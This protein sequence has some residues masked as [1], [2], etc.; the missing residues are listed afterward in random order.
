MIHGMRGKTLKGQSE[1]ISDLIGTDIEAAKRMVQ[2]L[3]EIPM[4]ISE[5]A[6][7]KSLEMEA[8]RTGDIELADMLI[9]RKPSKTIS[10]AGQELGMARIGDS[11]TFVGALRSIKRAKKRGIVDKAKIEK[12]KEA[13]KKADQQVTKRKERIKKASKDSWDSFITDVEETLNEITCK[14]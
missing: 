4:G 2:G 8:G 7:I 12:S 3:Q 9:S 5:V 13:I 1:I 11:D 10:L 14:T 6:L